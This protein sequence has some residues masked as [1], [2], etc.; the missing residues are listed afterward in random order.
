[1][2]AIRRFAGI[3][4][5]FLL[6]FALI[7]AVSGP[8][9][10]NTDGTMRYCEVSFTGCPQ[11]YDGQELVVPLEV[12]ALSTQIQ[13]CGITDSSI[14]TGG[15][16]APPAVMFIIDHTRSMTSSGGHDA[17]GNRFR[18]TRALI[19]SIYATVPEAEVGVIVFGPGLTM[20]AD[21]A[22]DPNLVRFNG[23]RNSTTDSYMPLIPLSSTVQVGT[24]NSGFLNVANYTGSDP[25]AIDMYRA[26]FITPPTGQAGLRRTPARTSGT[27]NRDLV[28]EQSGTNISIAFEAALEAFA[29]TNVPKE[30]QY[31]IFLSDG[32][33]SPTTCG[34]N[35]NARCP[36]QFNFIY[37][38]NTPTT[39]TVF[40]NSVG[41]RDRLPSV[42]DTLASIPRNSPLTPGSTTTVE[43]T[44]YR[45][46]NIAAPETVGGMTYNIRN[47]GYS[48]TNSSSD[49]WVLQSDYN[50]MLTL[51]MDNIITPMLSKVEGDAKSIVISSGNARD[52]TGAIGGGFTF[53]RRLPIDTTEITPISM[54][55]RYD[56]R[57]D[58]TFQNPVTGNDTTVTVRW[59]RD[60]LFVYD[61]TVRR[62]A[63]PPDNWQEAQ[64]LSTNCGA[65]P[66]L[67]LRFQN[68]TLAS[69]EKD[70]PGKE[71]KGNMDMLTV[72]FDNTGGLFD[73]S[74]GVTVTVMNAEGR[75]VEV[76]RELL[77]MTR[78]TGT[79]RDVWTATFPRSEASV[80]NPGDGR[81][82]H[83]PM[84]SII[85][86]FRNP[87]IPLDTLRIAV[88][89][90]ST[91]MAFYDRPGNPT[92]AN[93][94]PDDTTIIAGE[95]F[96]L[97]AKFFD[98]EGNWDQEIER[99]PERI[100]WTVSG[101]ANAT[102]TGEGVH[103]S[104]YS[105]T[106]GAYAV[107]ATYRDGPMVITRTIQIRVA[108]AAPEFLQIV[109]DTTSRGTPAKVD[110]SSLNT[111]TGIEFDRNTD[112]VELFVVERDRF[113]NLITNENGGVV[114]GGVD[115]NFNDPTGTVTIIPTPGGGSAT[116][117][118]DGGNFVDGLEVTVTKPDVPRS[119]KADITAVG[120][121][122]AGVG[123]NPFVPG[124]NVEQRLRDADPS[125]RTV[126]FYRHIITAPN[127][128]STGV[129]IAATP[130]RR[131][132]ERTALVMIYDA[133]GNT[134]FRSKP[135]D[136][137][138]DRNNQGNPTFGFVWDGKNNSGRTVGPGTY[139][140]R[141][142]AMLENG[143]RYSEAKKVGVT[144]E[145]R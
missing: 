46:L 6:T 122:T 79:N 45:L 77:T 33:P 90:V 37:G 120:P 76:D 85:V 38:E 108:P 145:R 18:V 126:E 63:S 5:A 40:L 60:S 71:A 139:L 55:V 141:I 111:T 82:Q 115:W 124:T 1:M 2:A 17:T 87:E 133:V 43:T 96:D 75:F 3:G 92:G 91:T 81:L 83:M 61:F 62:T 34:T 67:I 15:G 31:I 107:T 47:N 65:Q 88:P 123:P 20:G 74:S 58:S 13:A 143:E 25:R 136:I 114:A 28:L 56:V 106:V 95:R 119:D 41:T 70:I 8:A 73:Y 53:S 134:V 112:R 98:V 132:R 66:T 109:T 69:S 4:T 140:V 51:M 94:L 14:S 49:V 142:T 7:V 130:P 128:S 16:G 48:E 89:Y 11:D 9:L 27:G 129:L 86:V 54:G 26:M 29:R 103:G 59:A 117:V 21:S 99:H 93:Q 19:D 39:Y 44:L 24:G 110:T 116:F 100:T 125:G 12:V 80:A 30:N 32:E 118:R 72:V 22:N 42:L 97:Y 101:A 35:A 64:K 23:V 68:D 105:E 57:I 131:I 121:S 144:T 135:G 36:L 78:G 102:I 50:A 137:K 127:T 84:D 10:S 138:E 113:G 52:S 104:F